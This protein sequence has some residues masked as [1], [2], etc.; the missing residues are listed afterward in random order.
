[1][2]LTHRIAELTGGIP[3]VNT[4][5]FTRALK[6]I[7]AETSDYYLLGYNSSNP[8]PLQRTRRIEIRVKP[9]PKRRTDGYQLTY[10][11]SYTLTPK[12]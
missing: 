9:T 1:M 12:S 3:V 4:N 2:E 7:D 6:R 11:T 8:D 10:K 5:D